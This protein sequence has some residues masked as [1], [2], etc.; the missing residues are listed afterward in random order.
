MELST[1]IGLIEPGCRHLQKKAAVWADLGCGSGLF[2]RALSSFLAPGSK[3][4]AIDKNSILTS[5]ISSNG[6]DII[7]VTADFIRDPLPEKD[8][9]GI[10]MANA[11]HYVK[12]KPT[13][14]S[15]SHH[16]LKHHASFLVVEYDTDVPVIPWVP[17]PEKFS[18]LQSLFQAAGYSS[19]QRL[20]EH[21]SAFR[22]QLLYAALFINGHQ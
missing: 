6:V 7:P 2:T 12:D 18:G 11:L 3:V 10:L 4:Y 1:A 22:E 19:G 20:G 17:Y 9:D 14:L 21:P 16:Y 13:F 15:E 8:L 5:Q